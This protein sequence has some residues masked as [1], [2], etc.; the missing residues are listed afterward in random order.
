MEKKVKYKHDTDY[1]ITIVYKSGKKVSKVF[2]GKEMEEKIKIIN[3]HKSK[4]KYYFIETM[5]IHL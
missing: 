1:K 5:V 2:K 3:Q 4:I